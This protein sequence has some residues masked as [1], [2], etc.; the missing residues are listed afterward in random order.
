[1]PQNNAGTFTE[2]QNDSLSPGAAAVALRG[3]SPDATLVL[4]NGRRV[5]P[6]PSRR[7]VS[8]RLLI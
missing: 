1:M 2:N 6:I 3:L 5:A 7:Q 4:M 8:R